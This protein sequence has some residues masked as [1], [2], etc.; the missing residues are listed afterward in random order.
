MFELIDFDAAGFGKESG[1]A[2]CVNS[3]E[4]DCLSDRLS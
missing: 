3:I 4:I 2:D 1:A